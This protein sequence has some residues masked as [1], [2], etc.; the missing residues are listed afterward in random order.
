MQI[1]DIYFSNNNGDLLSG[2]LYTPHSGIKAGVIFSHGLFS[3]K[4]GYKITTLAQSIV[5]T[6][7]S[8]LTYNFS[9]VENN[10]IANILVSQE[11]NDLLGAIQFIRDKGIEKIHLMGSSMGG[12]VTL[13]CVMH[14][15]EIL[16]DVLLS[17]ITIATPVDFELLFKTI[18][19]HKDYS[20]L[21]EKGSTE[22]DSIPINNAFIIEGLQL[23]IKENLDEITVPYLLFHGKT[24]AVVDF[25]NVKIIKNSVKEKLKCIEIEQGDH[26]LVKEKEIEIIKN[27]L[28]D[29]LNGTYKIIT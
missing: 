16:N 4:N 20:T 1:E 21:P 2:R 11:V 25:S 22:I 3:N 14:N 17:I 12:A 28:V 26:T 24:D 15:K 19:K 6:G 27:E 10:D 7:H 13:L 9:F 29:W 5:E 23:D 8:L 18:I